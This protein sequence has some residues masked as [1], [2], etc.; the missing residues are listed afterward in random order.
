MPKKSYNRKSKRSTRKHRGYNFSKKVLKIID[1]QKE[2]KVASYQLL[3]GYVNDDITQSDIR[4]LQPNILQGTDSNQR[5]GDSVR[6]KR[7]VIRGYYRTATPGFSTNSTNSRIQL[8]QLIMSQRGASALNLLQHTSVFDAN[9][10]LENSQAYTG[11]TLDYITPINK[12]AFSVKR[13]RRWTLYQPSLVTLPAGQDSTAGVGLNE[14]IK[15]FTHEWNCNQKLNYATGGSA[16]SDDFKYFML[17]A[18]NMP[19]G[20]NDDT[21]IRLT[22]HVTWYYTDS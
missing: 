15:Y 14:S 17:N 22:Y 7:C 20:I 4:T 3:D 5:I 18:V 8:R 2:M 13:Q 6:L 19:D 11:S 1:N 9:N 10:L 21:A 12:S 16:Q